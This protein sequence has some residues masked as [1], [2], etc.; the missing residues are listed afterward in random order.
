MNE[1]IKKLISEALK[2]ESV[3]SFR[4]GLLASAV[5]MLLEGD[6]NLGFYLTVF[7]L[8]DPS[9]ENRRNTVFCG[10]SCDVATALGMEMID[11]SD[12]RYILNNAK[13]LLDLFNQDLPEGEKLK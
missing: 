2:V 12:V 9:D 5:S 10:Q 7:D 1:K 13:G 4:D 11:D 6:K 3:D 8:K